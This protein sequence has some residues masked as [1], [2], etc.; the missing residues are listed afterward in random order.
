MDEEIIQGVMDVSADD[1]QDPDDS[2]VLP[3]FSPKEA[4]LA[5]DT[6]KNYLIQNEKNIPDLIYALLKVKDEIVF[7][8][9]AK[10]NELTIDAYFSKE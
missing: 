4:F 2:S 6:L 8:S 7:N 9:Q 5:V 1:E 10:K 3:H